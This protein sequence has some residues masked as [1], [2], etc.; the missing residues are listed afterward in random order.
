MELKQH[1]RAGHIPVVVHSA[2]NEEVTLTPYGGAIAGQ[3]LLKKIVTIVENNMAQSAFTA[4]R[5]IAY[6]IVTKLP[7]NQIQLLSLR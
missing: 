6:R 5:L 4:G 3:A 7:G 1:A 2:K